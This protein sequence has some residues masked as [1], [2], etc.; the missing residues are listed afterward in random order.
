MTPR[1]RGPQPLE[2]IPSIDIRGGRCV[3][4]VRESLSTERVYASDPVAVAE[5]WRAR[6]VGDSVYV[7]NE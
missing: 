4:F 3:G 5:R 7:Q 1:P 2:M 6:I